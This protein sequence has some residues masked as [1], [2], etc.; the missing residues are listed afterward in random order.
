MSEKVTAVG[1]WWRSRETLEAGM[2]SQSHCLYPMMSGKG[3]VRCIF[4]TIFYWSLFLYPSAKRLCTFPVALDTPIPCYDCSY[5]HTL[6]T[7]SNLD[8]SPHLSVQIPRSQLLI[9][10]SPAGKLRDTFIPSY[11][12]SF[13][14]VLCTVR[15]LFSHLSVGRHLGCFHNLAIMSNAVVNTRMQVSLQYSAF[16]SLDIYPGGELLDQ[17]QF[18]I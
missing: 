16:I 7:H 14:S 13:H 3:W 11:Q 18:Y 12:P 15:F 2:N 6:K 5:R 9:H 10:W 4:N 1:G 17:R 8:L